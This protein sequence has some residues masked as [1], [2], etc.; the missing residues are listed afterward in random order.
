M[1]YAIA[2]IFCMSN[3]RAMNNGSKIENET[4]L[5]KAYL[6]E[7]KEI[8]NTREI[9]EIMI[10]GY[11]A[12]V[13]ICTELGEQTDEVK[14][15]QA[16]KEYLEALLK[17]NSFK[18][19]EPVK[20]A[21]NNTCIIKGV[22][23]NNDIVMLIHTIGNDVAGMLVDTKRSHD[24]FLYLKKPRE[25]FEIISIDRLLQVPAQT[26]KNGKGEELSI[27]ESYIIE[28]ST[29]D[30]HYK[31]HWERRSSND[32]I[33]EETLDRADLHFNDMNIND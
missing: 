28:T 5:C 27:G 10:D 21:K 15:F 31:I 7:A 22:Q 23:W 1:W 13:G 26:I 30:G 6:K 9:T 14:K 20:D 11:S 32:E 29:N 12:V 19:S 17:T 25:D 4:E 8:D 2:L 16:C 18:A 33:D 24:D 3:L